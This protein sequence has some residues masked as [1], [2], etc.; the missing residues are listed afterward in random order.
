MQGQIFGRHAAV[1]VGVVVEQLDRAFEAPVVSGLNLDLREHSSRPHLC[2]LGGGIITIHG[3]DR[4]HFLARRL[5]S[6]T[7]NQEGGQ[8]AQ[9]NLVI[10][11]GGDGLAE[12]AIRIVDLPEHFVALGYKHLALG[13]SEA[14][15]PSCHRLEGG[16]P[17]ASREL[18]REERHPS[19]RLAGIG[20][21][22]LLQ[23][24]LRTIGLAGAGEQLP[25]PEQ[26]SRRIAS[27]A[28][29]AS[30]RQCHGIV[31]LAGPHVDFG[32]ELLQA[33]EAIRADEG[34]GLLGLLE[35]IGEVEQRH[36]LTDQ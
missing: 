32:G 20:I 13:R 34:E 35:A 1:A 31:K 11:G 25:E 14:F 28:S 29:Q 12:A 17:S 24:L 4:L 16:L 7:S 3:D 30:F 15:L 36:E 21:D 10:W 33:V 19:R 6:A 5:Q 9:R 2:P 26:I 18:V 27:G 22:R 23:R 8:A